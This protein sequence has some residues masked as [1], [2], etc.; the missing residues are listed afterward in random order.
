M[1]LDHILL[2]DDTDLLLNDGSFVLLNVDLGV[3][4]AGTHP[5][6]LVFARGEQLIDVEFTFWLRAALLIRTLI[7]FRTFSCLIRN[8]ASN[9]KLK[10]CLRRN[11]ESSAK[12]KSALLRKESSKKVNVKSHTIP[13]KNLEQFKDKAKLKKV[14]LR[15]LKEMMDE[16]G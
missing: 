12:V 13:S 7:T 5:T 4:L 2:N 6:Q 9:I 16:D 11:V 1:V 14:L 15:K 8:V 3:V 10:S